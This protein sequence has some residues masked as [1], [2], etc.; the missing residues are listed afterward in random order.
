MQTNIYANFNHV[1]P[2]I[3]AKLAV[4]AE[5]EG[6]DLEEYHEQI[7]AHWI[8]FPTKLSDI[9]PNIAK[10]DQTLTPQQAQIPNLAQAIADSPSFAKDILAM[11]KI[12]GHDDLFERGQD[13]RD[14]DFDNLNFNNSDFGEKADVSH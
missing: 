9:S 2:S 12:E 7:L 10:N 4:M 14:L 3:F 1:S 13:S 5:A 11:P 8:Q 6:F